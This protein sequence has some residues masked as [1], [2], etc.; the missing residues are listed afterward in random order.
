MAE[1]YVRN[2]FVRL[3]KIGDQSFLINGRQCF[4]VNEIG[5]F[6][7]NCFSTPTDI[8]VIRKKVL[9]SYEVENEKKIEHDLYKFIEML[10]K[11]DLIDKV[12]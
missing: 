1:K 8:D 11:F 5:A 12:V 7:W 9:D 4:E 10:K 2:I 3:G 6:I